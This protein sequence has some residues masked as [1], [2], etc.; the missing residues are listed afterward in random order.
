M[1][2]W[3]EVNSFEYLWFLWESEP[4]LTDVLRDK[5]IP[6]SDWE[7]DENGVRSVMETVVEKRKRDAIKSRIAQ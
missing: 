3:G 6:R 1:L 4:N 2:W 5:K 7:I